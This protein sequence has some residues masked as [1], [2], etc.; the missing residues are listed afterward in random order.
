[1]D[2][3]VIVRRSRLPAVATIFDAYVEPSPVTIRCRV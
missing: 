2:E 1:M 3:F